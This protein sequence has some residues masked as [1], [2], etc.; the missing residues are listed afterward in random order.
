MDLQS[1]LNEAADMLGLS[2]AEPVKKTRKKRAKK[3]AK[4]TKAAKASKATKPVRKVG[5]PRKETEPAA[6]PRKLP[7]TKLLNVRFRG[8]SAELTFRDLRKLRTPL[9]YLDKR[10][11]R[12]T[13][14]DLRKVEVSRN[15]KS[16]S[17]A[18][19]GILVDVAHALHFED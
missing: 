19:K 8:D 18:D 14:A 5:R 15:G 3:Q 13:P 10:L 2:D 1:T 4:V 16:I 7:K 17:W 12:L 11:P 9:K 6:K